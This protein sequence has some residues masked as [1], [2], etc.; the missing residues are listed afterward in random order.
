[1]SYPQSILELADDARTRITEVEA[2]DLRQD[3]PGHWLYLDVREEIEFD[4]G[5]IEG[6]LHI[7]RLDLRDE[8]LKAIPDKA[9]PI[10]AYCAVGHRS[11]LAADELTDL[12]YRHVVSL[13]G[14][15]NALDQL[16]SLRQ[17]A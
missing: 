17:V 9:T 7:P 8:I 3:P 13:K 10:V 5:H 2:R 4:Q 6:A 12:G 1:M 16:D 15:L 11:A 14:G